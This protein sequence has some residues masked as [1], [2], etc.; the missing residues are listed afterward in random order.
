V[1]TKV[2][3]GMTAEVVTDTDKAPKITSSSSSANE[4][5]VAQLNS[6]GVVPPA[7]IPT[8]AHQWRYTGDFA[9]GTGEVVVD[10]GDGWET[11]DTTPQAIYS[12]AAG[13]VTVNEGVFTFPR[14]GLWLV[15]LNALFVRNSSDVTLL[16]A[17]LFATT[18]SGGST[19]VRVG[20]ACTSV[21]SANLQSSVVISSLINVS[22]TADV[23]VKVK[24]SA[25]SSGADFKGNSTFNRSYFTFL[26]VGP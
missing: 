25:S 4:G 19:E 6:D 2:Q 1:A 3:S 24:V 8:F 17:D 5:K 22:A 12:G 11:V 20:Q 26:K 13:A 21:S 7:Y 15:T 18:G 16:V 9:V 14:T 23:K 10:T